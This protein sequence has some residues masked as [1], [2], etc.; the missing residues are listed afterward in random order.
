MSEALV[1]GSSDLEPIAQ[2]S[3]KAGCYTDVDVGG[4]CRVQVEIP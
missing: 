2:C 3:T 1:E 4:A